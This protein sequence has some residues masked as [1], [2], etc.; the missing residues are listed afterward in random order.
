MLYKYKK[1]INIIDIFQK[2]YYKKNNI[3]DLNYVINKKNLIKTILLSIEPDNKNN[4]QICNDCWK[5]NCRK[6][7]N[8]PEA[9]GKYFEFKSIACIAS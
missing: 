6:I 7:Y 1:G 2:I 3:L 9:I 4:N 5:N 8:T